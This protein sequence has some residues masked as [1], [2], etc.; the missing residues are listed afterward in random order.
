MVGY[1][2]DRRLQDCVKTDFPAACR[3]V[4]FLEFLL[5]PLIRTCLWVD[6]SILVGFRRKM[7][8]EIVGFRG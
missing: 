8:M 6:W 3:L 5:L 2:Q 4:D 7:I 1:C